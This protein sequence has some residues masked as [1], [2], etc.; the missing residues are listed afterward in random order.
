MTI[1]KKDES[2]KLNDVCYLK[3]VNFF[4][5]LYKLYNVKV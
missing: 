5:V 3:T 4:R 2:N 1:S